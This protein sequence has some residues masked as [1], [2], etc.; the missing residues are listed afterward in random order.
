MTESAPVM[1]EKKRLNLQERLGLISLI[2]E[3]MRLGSP[4]SPL[5]ADLF[6]DLWDL[7]DKT[8]Q[9]SKIDRLKPEG[10]HKIFR[11]LEISAGT[12]QTLGRLNMLYLNKPMPCYYLVYVEVMAPFRRQ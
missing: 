1:M 3:G 8:A 10:G 7:V 9:G 6:N 2:D 4:E 11:V 12:G 5:M